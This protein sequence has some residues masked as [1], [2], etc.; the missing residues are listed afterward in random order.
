MERAGSFI[1]AAGCGLGV[2]VVVRARLPADA[3]EAWAWP[4]ATT[5]LLMP[6]VYPWYLVWLT[7]F[8]TSRG[9]WPLV[10]WTLGVLLTY[11]VWISELGG[12]GWVLPVWV[13]P[14]EYGLLI[15]SI[16]LGWMAGWD[17]DPSHPA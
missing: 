5:L 17:R 6:V 3:P 15:G 11:V 12:A 10:T 16:F 7:P 9:T 8:L 2:A 14:V 13:Q 1:L 4:M